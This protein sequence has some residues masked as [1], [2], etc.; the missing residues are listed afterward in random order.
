MN[1]NLKRNYCVLILIFYLVKWKKIILKIK[2]EVF[3]NIIEDKS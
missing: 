1:I 2:I 3:I